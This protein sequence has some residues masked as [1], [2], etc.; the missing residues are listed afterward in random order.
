M[1]FVFADRIL[2]TSTTTGAGD[3]AVA[4][5]VTGFR[6]FSAAMAVGDTCYY[7]A[8]DVDSNGNPSGGYE[9]GF[10]TYSSANTLTRTIV[11]NSSNSNAAVSWAAGTRRIMMTPLAE[12]PPFSWVNSAGGFAVPGSGAFEISIDGINSLTVGTTSS[13]GG[14]ENNGGELILIGAGMVLGRVRAVYDTGTGDGI[15]LLSAGTGSPLRLTDNGL[16]VPYVPSPVTPPADSATFALQRLN[17]AGGRVLPR[18]LSEDGTYMSMQPHMGRNSI[19]WLQAQGGGATAFST[20]GMIGATAV[21]TATGRAQTTTNKL[22]RARRV[23][24]VSAATAGSQGGYYYNSSQGTQW[25]VGGVAGGGF[26]AIFLFAPS[27]AATV[28]GAHMFVGMGSGT[29]LPG[30]TTNPSAVTNCIG[31]AQLN[32]GANLNIVYG[33]SAAQTPIDLGASFPA[34]ANGIT[35]GNLYELMLYARPDDATKVAYRVE[36]LSVP[37][38]ASGILTGVAGTALPSN[39]TFLAPRMYRSNNGTAL[40]TGIDI[41]RHYIESEMV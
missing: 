31:V 8:F 38:V 29:S 5:A 34:G 30:A 28:A 41:L 19:A 11:I 12:S 40:A 24:Y 4:A 13:A 26:L 37:A 10:G 23:G 16:I 17:A 18:W 20:L 22:S 7:A 6:R 36:N 14:D 15:L 32:G 33:G 9:T 25:T 27:D 3:Y 1:A 35:S 39:S 21:G 2:E